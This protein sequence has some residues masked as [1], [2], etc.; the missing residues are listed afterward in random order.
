VAGWDDVAWLRR[1]WDGPLLIKGITTVEDAQSAA[2]AAQVT[3]ANDA[4]SSGKNF[5]YGFLGLG[6]LLSLI[7]GFLTSRSNPR[8]AQS[9]IAARCRR[10]CAPG[11]HRPTPPP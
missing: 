4:Y 8:S 3:N 1:L 7:L 9:S 2:A 11:T 5:V 6:L 10:P